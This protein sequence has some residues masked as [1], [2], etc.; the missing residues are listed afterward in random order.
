[1]ESRLGTE[2]IDSK[3]KKVEDEWLAR[4]QELAKAR[5]EISKL[6]KARTERLV[7]NSKNIGL[8]AFNKTFN[9]DFDEPTRGRNEDIRAPE[10]ERLR[11][12]IK[13]GLRDPSLSPTRIKPRAWSP[14]L[15]DERS[16]RRQ[17]QMKQND[18][19]NAESPVIYRSPVHSPPNSKFFKELSE[20]LLQSPTRSV[21]FNLNE[22]S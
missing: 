7:R 17:E 21:T 10:T 6:D 14:E 1:Y 3:F 15:I 5:Q 8:P 20:E 18:T 22:Y 9:F 11:N 2:N 16:H 12:A 4:K 19:S 13:Q